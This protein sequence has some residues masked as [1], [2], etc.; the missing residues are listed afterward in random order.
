MS[1]KHEIKIIRELKEQT[2]KKIIAQSR[3]KK[4]SRQ[5]KSKNIVSL[6]D[7]IKMLFTLF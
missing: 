2:S 7:Y 1:Q 4:V 5:N 6:L 3:Y